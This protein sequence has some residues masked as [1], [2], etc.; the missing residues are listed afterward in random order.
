MSNQASRTRSVLDNS[1]L[2]KIAL[3]PAIKSTT[4]S[5][6]LSSVV[7]GKRVNEI[8]MDKQPGL[9]SAQSAFSSPELILNASHPHGLEDAATNCRHFVWVPMSCCTPQL[10]WLPDGG[11]EVSR[12][13]DCQDT[14]LPHHITRGWLTLLSDMKSWGLSSILTRLAF[15]TKSSISG[16]GL[17]TSRH[18]STSSYASSVGSGN[19]PTSRSHL[20]ARSTTNVRTARPATSMGTREENKV[21]NGQN[22]MMPPPCLSAK[23]SGTSGIPH[24]KVRKYNSAQDMSTYEPLAA[25]RE[26]SFCNQ[27]SSLSLNG[28][29]FR[30]QETQ[31]TSPPSTPTPVSTA[32]IKSGIPILPAVTARSRLAGAQ[33]LEWTPGEGSQNGQVAPKTPSHRDMQLFIQRLQN[34]VK[35][36]LTPAR[37]ASPSPTKAA[38]LSKYSNVTGFVATDIDER[39]GKFENDFQK[40]KD[41][42]DSAAMDKDRYVEELDLAK[43]RG[44]LD[45]PGIGEKDSSLCRILIILSDTT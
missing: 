7:I 30:K 44:R 13:P 43:R 20:R 18:T 9:Y 28:S 34:N 12:E 10:I 39:L 33:N 6:C 25:S 29:T 41:M 37:G 21:Q 11:N 27:F 4:R 5:G 24:R 16:T 23:K 19:R 40:M 31:A 2:K 14:S 15:Q 38:Y 22:G 35:D 45:N 42:M 1:P 8:A 36:A 32:L 26:A 17:P 3:S